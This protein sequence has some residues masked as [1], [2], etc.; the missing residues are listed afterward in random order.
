[1]ELHCDAACVF[2]R[3]NVCTDFFG[4]TYIQTYS[5]MYMFNL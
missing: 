3:M 2:M 5:S 4:C 1:M